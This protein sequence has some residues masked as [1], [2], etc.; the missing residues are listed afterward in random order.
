MARIPLAQQIAELDAPAPVDV[1]PEAIFNDL[2]TGSTEVSRAHYVDVGKQLL[3][4]DVP[5]SEEEEQA[6]EDEESQEGSDEEEEEE[7]EAG[8]QKSDNDPSESDGDE[9]AQNATPDDTAREATDITITLRKTQDEDRKKGLAVSRQLGIWDAL[10]DARIRLQKSVASSNTL[11]SSQLPQNEPE[12]Q[13]SLNRMLNEAALFSEQLFELQET[14]LQVND[15][16]EPPARKR[17]KIETF[18]I[19]SKRTIPTLYKL[20]QSGPP[21][22]KLSLLP[23]SFPLIAMLSQMTAKT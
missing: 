17:R 20:Y 19:L 9:E 16:I 8:P 6:E 12:Y 5:S 13:E 18:Q 22:F 7:E 21:K 1:D 2:H 23:S 15:S 3:D 11:P 10:L 14:L 4:D